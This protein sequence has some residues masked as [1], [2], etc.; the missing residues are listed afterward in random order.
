MTTVITERPFEDE[1]TSKRL[2]LYNVQ[3]GQVNVYGSVVKP[4]ERKIRELEA[5]VKKIKSGQPSLSS[6]VA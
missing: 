6:K 5:T 4:T 2:T 3:V 1:V